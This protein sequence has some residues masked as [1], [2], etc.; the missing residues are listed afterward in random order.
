M[1]SNNGLL[2]KI[3]DISVW[4]V[5]KW[6]MVIIS[7]FIELFILMCILNITEN[8]V[9]ALV[10]MMIV[11]IF[12]YYILKCLNY[13]A[14]KQAL[15][16]TGKH[17]RLKL[18]LGILLLYMVWLGMGLNLDKISGTGSVNVNLTTQVIALLVSLSY[19]F[20][21]LTLNYEESKLD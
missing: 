14:A 1:K 10:I 11:N 12:G 21:L 17:S 3:N 7:P 5:M 4:R 13:C 15:L 20:I 9:L 2:D 6:I 8:T 19:G 16:V 18:V